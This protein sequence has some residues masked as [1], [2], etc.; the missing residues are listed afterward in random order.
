MSQKRR[1]IDFTA[2]ELVETL[3]SFE[4]ISLLDSGGQTH[5]DSHLLIAGFRPVKVLEDCELR[6]LDGELNFKPTVNPKSEIRNPK[7]ENLACI[8]TFSYDFGLRFENLKPRKKEFQNFDEPDVFLAFYE[9]LVVYDYLQQKAF[10]VGE[11][12]EKAEEILRK[13]KSNR[14]QFADCELSEKINLTSNFS[15]ETYCQAVETIKEHIRCGDIYQANLT[16]QF[17]AQLPPDFTPAQTFLRLRR[18]HPAPFGAFIKRRHDTVISAS[19]ERFLQVKN[20]TV[21]AAPI[22]GT[23]K[24]GKNLFEDEK[25]RQELINSEKDRAEN[26]MIVDLLRNDLGRVCEFGSVTVEKLCAIEEH[27]TLFHLVSTIRGKLRQNTKFSDLLKAAFP[28]GSITGAPKIRAMQILDEIETA[29]RGLSMGAIGYFGFDNEIDLNVA[30]RTM[31]IR[32][33]NAIFNVGG[34]IVIDSVPEL[35]Y[36]ESLIKAQALLNALQVSNKG[37]I[38]LP[39]RGRL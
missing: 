8:A 10:L 16:Q 39:F 17:R 21:I 3:L 31:V 20:Q 14:A 7:S 25:L 28:C 36:E 32:D 34:G 11:N 38:N 15:P 35:E 18:T 23:R 6:S 9:N 29:P 1:E 22:K 5:G 37:K 4:Q 30:I 27:P 33:Q 24:R 13:A 26:V 12:L 2:D 19:P